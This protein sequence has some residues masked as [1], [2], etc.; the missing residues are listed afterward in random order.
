MNAID[1][2]PL[3]VQP[4]S[5]IRLNLSNYYRIR[6]WQGGGEFWEHHN[7]QLIR[8]TLGQFLPR[9]T[10]DSSNF[11]LFQH[12]ENGK[13]I[14]SCSQPITAANPIPHAQLDELR[15]ALSGFKAKAS[16]PKCDPEAR[17]L[18]DCF[19]L[20][21]PKKDPELY[22]IYGT[23]KN[24]R[25]VVLWGAEKEVDSAV[26]PLEAISRVHTEP[27]GQGKGNTRSL[28]V[29]ALVVALVVLGWFIWQREKEKT[30]ATQSSVRNDVSKS[31]VT[32]TGA[33]PVSGT[34]GGA[35]KSSIGVSH[36]G[37]NTNKS[38]SGD[39]MA[40]TGGDSIQPGLA[41]KPDTNS[42][43]GITPEAG[44]ARTAPNTADIAGRPSKDGDPSLEKVGTG[45]TAKNDDK[46][47]VV[48]DN[49]GGSVPDV[50]NPSQMTG[51][52]EESKVRSED[53][54]P[55]GQPKSPT[56]TLADGK[57]SEQRPDA[58]PDKSPATNGDGN[59]P[60]GKVPG[61]SGAAAYNTEENK[62]ATT[63]TAELTETK[64]RIT[65]TIPADSKST[66]TTQ[67]GVAPTPKSGELEIIKV[68]VGGEPHDGKVEV[69]LGLRARD[70]N[71]KD[72]Q[73]AQATWMVDGK[74]LKHPDGRPLSDPSVKRW[75]SVGNRTVSVIGRTSDGKEM[76]G[77]AQLDVKIKQQP[78]P[79][80]EL[81]NTPPT[82][83][84]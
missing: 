4:D 26:A 34:G 66:P 29:A 12:Y 13:E 20:P 72:I 27:V 1:K 64:I 65:D 28:L 45:T 37:G 47:S 63:T 75:L 39:P 46:S 56:E 59:D 68:D 48:A 81:K 61:N 55:T 80:V 21:D 50:N 15:F 79:E 67:P 32:T 10:V 62:P 6:T 18:I 74:P 17:K 42:S 76:R 52:G 36:T 60:G 82:K 54:T 33:N 23:G 14:C 25:L 43:R 8:D 69:M 53:T 7:Q 35:A 44:A 73:I 22:R 30:V 40:T 31:E 3:A 9:A 41:A 24:R 71:L 49:T 58:R 84:K 51:G 11:V 77:E 70:A 16:D 19:R 57:S 38:G 83:N 2:T 78:K 5:G